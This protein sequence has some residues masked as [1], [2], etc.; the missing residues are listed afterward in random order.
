LLTS[1]T[2]L[3]T[4]DQ[5]L[6]FQ[7]I[8]KL[9]DVHEPESS[10]FAKAT[11]PAKKPVREQPPG[12]KM[13]FQ[14]L[15]FGSRNLGKIESSS[16]SVGAA[17]TESGSDAEMTEAPAS[18]RR[19]AS[20]ESEDS[21]SDENDSSESSESED[22]SSSDQE[23]TEAPRLPAKSVVTPRAEK[24]STKHISNDGSP[25]S[26]LK[27]THG[28]GVEKK[29]KTSSSQSKPASGDRQLKR[30][31]TK[32]TVS[33]TSSADIQPAS[34]KTHKTTS[35]TLGS[36]SS[37]SF[38]KPAA[39]LPP[40]SRTILPAS[41]SPAPRASQSTPSNKTSELKPSSEKSTSKKRDRDTPVKSSRDEP[42]LREITQATDPRLPPEERREKITKLKKQ[43]KHEDAGRHSQSSGL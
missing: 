5:T 28:E 31:K 39:I 1:S 34:I 23:M 18:F 33:Q 16:S 35:S 43:R 21:D 36:K 8:V 15:G 41:S 19:P 20:I 26:S 37:S 6:H 42:S 11:V 25:S 3:K 30:L 29:A 22:S 17:S 10:N 4:I 40:L 13:R 38:S 9:S 12:L 24:S 14:P 7:Q 32:Q 2:V 27:R